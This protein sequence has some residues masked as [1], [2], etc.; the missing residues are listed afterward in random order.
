MADPVI[1]LYDSAGQTLATNDN[2]QTDTNAGQITADGLAPSDPAEAA[3]RATLEPGAYTAVVTGKDSTQGI[4]LVE[5]YDLSPEGD[6]KLANM[7]TRGLVGTESDLLIAGFI[8]GDVDNST[9]VIRSLGPSLRA[10]GIGDPLND[11]S[12]TVYDQNGS[13]LVTNDNWR[14]D[15]SALDL[16]QN[17]IAPTNDAEAATILHLPV[18]AY[19][20]VTVGAD[21]GTGVG[22]VEVYNLE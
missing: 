8:V 20:S 19:T 2:W 10:A 22:L 14:D 11:P 18:G 13:P 7:S 1:T 6:S 15:P 16:E 9:V 4:G 12:F 3:L 17:Q 21:G 5:V